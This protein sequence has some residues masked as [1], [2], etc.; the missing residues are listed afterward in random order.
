VAAVGRAC[1][2]PGAAHPAPQPL[3]TLL[4][5]RGAV[6]ASELDAALTEQREARG[7][8][9][10]EILV[11]R[12]AASPAVVEEALAEQ[13]RARGDAEAGFGTGLRTQL[14]ERGAEARP[15]APPLPPVDRGEEPQPERRGLLRRFEGR[16][17][18]YLDEAAA[19]LD[20]RGVELDR[21]RHELAALAERLDAEE[22]ELEARREQLER[23]GL[24]V[25]QGPLVDELFRH[26]E[27]W[28]ALASRLQHERAALVE[29]LRRARREL[30]LRPASAPEAEPAS[31]HLVFLHGA[32]GYELHEREGPPPLLGARVEV[33]EGTAVVV[34]VGRS[35]LP[36][37]RR[38]CAFVEPDEAP[39]GT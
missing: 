27:H 25:D 32:A 8:L 34:K 37:D 31:T 15:P 10:G 30:S 11:R 22:R 20:D 4:L 21:R 19:E 9:L 12:G 13:R 5:Q 38:P 24:R 6:S 18:R 28:T 2:H 1:D 3:G 26:V 17:E 7:G 16:L 23:H 36:L 14:A 35:P 33:G 29:Q 39:S